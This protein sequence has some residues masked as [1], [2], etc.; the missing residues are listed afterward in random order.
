MSECAV[1]ADKGDAYISGHM[2]WYLKQ[3]KNDLQ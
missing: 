1:G 2:W 3:M